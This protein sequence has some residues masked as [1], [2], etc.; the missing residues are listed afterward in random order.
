[1][2][3]LWLGVFLA[4]LT[5]LPSRC[6]SIPCRDRNSLL[7]ISA[8]GHHVAVANVRS[9]IPESTF[10]HL[11]TIDLSTGIRREIPM[12][13][14]PTLEDAASSLVMRG[15]RLWVDGTAQQDNLGAIS[16]YDLAT[17]EEQEARWLRCIGGLS[18]LSL[19]RDGKRALTLNFDRGPQLSVWDVDAGR[20]LC[21]I[22]EAGTHRVFNEEGTLVVTYSEEPRADLEGEDLRWRVYDA[23]TGELKGKRTEKRPPESE[24]RKSSEPILQELGPSLRPSGPHQSHFLRFGDGNRTILTDGIRDCSIWYWQTGL[25]TRDISFSPELVAE[26]RFDSRVEP[27]APVWTVTPDGRWAVAASNE[28]TFRDTILRRL[29]N[30]FPAAMTGIRLDAGVI[31]LW[32]VRSDRL[33]MTIPGIY[34]D[35]AISDSGETLARLRDGQVEVWS[36]PPRRPWIFAFAGSLLIPAFWAYRRRRGLL[37]DGRDR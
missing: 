31:R 29:S 14:S 21:S 28:R 18:G 6:I 10:D 30:W 33:V 3:L 36:N 32:D 34:H 13:R 4:L 23:A 12:H 26:K 15:G 35:L 8:E 19:S 5:W 24:T 11:A 1:M 25:V 22:E 20:L 37:L 9:R 17:G 7:G 16:V 27:Q 2:G